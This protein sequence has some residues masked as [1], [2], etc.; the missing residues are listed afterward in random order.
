[1]NVFDI[2][3][4]VMVGPSSSHT[5]GA[6]KIGYT[7]RKLIRED[8]KE[9][10][11]YL[12]GSFLATGKGHGTHKALIAGLMGMKPDDERIPDSFNYAK[13]MGLKFE[14]LGIDLRDAHPNSVMLK[15][16]GV[17][18]NKIEIVASSI[19]GG[20][21]IINQIDGAKADITA[22]YPTLI[23]KNVDKP[24]HVSMVTSLLSK[25]DI[26]IATMRIHRDKRG[27]TAVMIIE[28]DQEVPVHVID[29]LTKAEGV[30]KI[31]YI[32]KVEA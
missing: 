32:D 11:I 15:L 7:A 28:C 3:G 24:G 19:G 2:M 29:L 25:Q 26:N 10:K 1:M 12:H 4:P 27:G 13:E 16:V 8:I 14:F 30:K 23:I 21:I 22:A 6:V 9:A 18:N 17:N 20:S 31:R 5:A